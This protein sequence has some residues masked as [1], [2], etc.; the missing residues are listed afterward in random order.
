MSA[1]KKIT[2]LTESQYLEHELLATEKHE[3]VD[4]QIYAM[5]GASENHNRIT[6]NI[7]FQLRLAARGGNCGVFSND[8]KLRIPHSRVYYYPDVMLMCQRNELDDDYYKHSPCLIAEVLSKSTQVTDK[9]E[10]LLNY[11][12]IASLHYY[13][14][15]DC[16]QKQVD[17]L[18]RDNNGNWQ[19][20][21]LEQGETLF[22]QCEKFA[23]AL[24]LDSLYEDVDLT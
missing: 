2:Y 14:M 18:Q 7:A 6:L 24:T 8:M 3:Y 21:T 9:R 4:G 5:A 10:K 1:L 13:L 19:R 11:Q 15:V 12:K 16:T 22:V 20:A 23:T 17:Y